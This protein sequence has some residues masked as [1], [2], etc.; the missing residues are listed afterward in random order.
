M[1]EEI[2]GDK[3]QMARLRVDGQGAYGPVWMSYQRKRA[4]Y[5]HGGGERGFRPIDNP[6]RS[7]YCLFVTGMRNGGSIS[8]NT[9]Q[10]AEEN[11]VAVMCCTRAHKGGFSMTADEC[12]REG[13][14]YRAWSN[15][16]RSDRKILFPNRRM[17]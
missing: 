10:I 16:V 8:L 6:D 4:L 11:L 7:E 5:D 9:G 17:W 1:S 2:A 3:A 13:K 12:N 14:R 15:F